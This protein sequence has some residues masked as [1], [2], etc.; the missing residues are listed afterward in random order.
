MHFFPSK[1]VYVIKAILPTLSIATPAVVDTKFLI[2][3]STHKT[4]E[5][6]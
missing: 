6:A 2:P 1:Q 5:I 3:Y 4:S